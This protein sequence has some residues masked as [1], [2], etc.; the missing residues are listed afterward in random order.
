V[1]TTIVVGG[2]AV[3][4]PPPPQAAMEVKNASSVVQD[5]PRTVADLL[6]TAT[7]WSLGPRGH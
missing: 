5:M 4:C 2:V 3:A 1:G 6:V 7:R